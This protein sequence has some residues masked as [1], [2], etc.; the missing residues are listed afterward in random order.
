MANVNRLFFKE[1]CK[2][3][4]ST[5]N[6]LIF[7][8]FLFSKKAANIDFF[9]NLQSWYTVLFSIFKSTEAK[10]TNFL[11]KMFSA[12][13]TLK[14]LEEEESEREDEDD[15]FNKDLNET[16]QVTM[17]FIRLNKV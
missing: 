12:V 1:Y 17:F 4:W 2:F 11:Q 13:H 3:V 9:Q 10:F 5:E 8:L 7:I 14:P 15:K 6:Y 16:H